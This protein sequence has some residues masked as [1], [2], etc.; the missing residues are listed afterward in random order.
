MLTAVNP[1]SGQ[2]IGHVPVTPLSACPDMMEQSRRAFAAWSRQPMAERIALLRRLREFIIAHLD[3]LVDVIVTSTGKPPVEAL[4]ADILVVVDM[5]HYLETHAEKVLSPKRVK[6][7]LLLLGKRSYVTYMPRG[8][9]LVIAPWNY[10]FQLSIVPAASALAAG[11]SVILKPSEVTPLVGQWIERLFQQAGAPEHLVQVAHGD[12]RVGAA[13]IEAN[14]DYIFFT[15]SVRTG[16]VVQQEAAKR[17]IPT[18]LELGGKDPMIVFADAPLERAAKGA[19][20]GALTNCGQVCMSVER[21]YVERPVYE[22]FLQLLRRELE[23]LSR[24]PSDPER[25]LGSM[26]F[27]KQRDIV[28]DHVTQALAQGARCIGGVPPEQWEAGPGLSVPPVMLTDLKEDMAVMREETF[29]PVLCVVPFDS[30]EEAV[31]LAN[32]TEYGLNASVWSRDL[33]KA[34]RVADRLVS[35]AVVINDVIVSVSNPHLPF[36]GAKASGIGRYHGEI[37]LQTFC[38]QKSIV[39]DRGRRKTEVQWYPYRGKREPFA[40]LIRSMY[41]PKRRWTEL[42]RAYRELL[43]RS[44][45]GDG[46]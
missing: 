20:W 10:P 23:R 40:R 24:K 38:H 46:P 8:V 35:G 6:T 44:K 27:P 28:R 42:L 29:G 21:I 9:V 7:P 17:L 5:L 43:R 18:T 31:R 36:G 11:N 3:E 22:P 15:G 39:V 19:V 16:K 4:T 33:A 12:G 25:D 41:G 45:E 14:P 2:V 30:E 34:W 26:T 13:L 32:G 1:A 37:G